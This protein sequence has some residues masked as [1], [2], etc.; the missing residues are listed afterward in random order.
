MT[1]ANVNK[2]RLMMR[3]AGAERLYAKRLSPNDNSKNQPYF[4]GDF[5]ILNILPYGDVKSEARGKR[6]N[7]K[8]AVKFHW[9]LDNGLLE[10]ASHAQF[11]LYPKY[12]E[13][14]FSGF[15]KGCKDAPNELMNSR[16]QGRL[17]FLG[18]TNNGEIIGHVAAP[19]SPLAR[20]FEALGSLPAVGVFNE[21]PLDAAQSDTRELLLAELRRIYVLGWI[22]SKRMIGP[23]QYKPCA[24]PHCAGMTLEAELGIMPNAYAE[25]DFHGWEVKQHHVTRLERPVTG[26]LTLMTPEPTGGFYKEYGV[27][28][29]IRKYGYQDRLGREDRWNFGGIHKIGER[30]QGTGLTMIL[31]GFDVITGTITDPDGGIVLC[32]DRENI[33]AKWN[34]SDVLGHWKRKHARAVYV[35]SIKRTAPLQYRYGNLV[36]LGIGTDPIKLLDAMAKKAV[37]YDPGIKL[38]KASGPRP[39]TKRRSQFRVHIRCLPTLYNNVEQ[40]D[41]AAMI[42]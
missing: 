5:S 41:V 27:A 24:A 12:P 37:Y 18:V 29:F 31:V 39:V 10:H 21:V 34:F 16:D 1:I 33:A 2:L 35:P 17:L 8:A 40:I 22:R 38:E 4:G 9:L 26:I 36:R 13:V 3:G 15:L 32:D 6:P 20:S 7:F 11:I 25:P 42:R 23:G 14:R 19:S 28:A 30:H